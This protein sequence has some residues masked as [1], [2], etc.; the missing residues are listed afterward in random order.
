MQRNRTFLTAVTALLI[1]Q[2]GVQTAR[3][4]GQGAN[5]IQGAWQVEIKQQNPPPGVTDFQSLITFSAGRTTVEENG[6]PGFGPAVGTWE[7]IRSGE[8]AATWLKPIYNPQTGALQGMV[9]IRARI[10]MKSPDEYESRDKVDFYLP[11]GTLAA[12]WT[13]VATGRRIK[14]ED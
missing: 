6:A 13:T 11:D 5:A 14:V 1:S 9:K 8:F 2:V 3:A 10:Q 7:F 4:Q 12:S